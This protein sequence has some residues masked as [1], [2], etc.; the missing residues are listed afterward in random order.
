M[1]D[2]TLFILALLSVLLISTVEGELGYQ[3]P[4]EI[5]AAHNQYR[6][7]VNVTPLT[8]SDTLAAQA[9]KCADSNAANLSSGGSFRHCFTPGYG[10]NIAQSPSTKGLNLT[11]MVDL[12]GSEKRYFVNGKFPSVS[13]TGSPKDVGHYTQ[14]IWQETKQVGCGKASASGRDILVCDYSPEGNVADTVVYSPLPPQP[15]QVG[16]TNLYKTYRTD[17]VGAERLIIINTVPNRPVSC[18]SVSPV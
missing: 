9:Q 2:R 7:E 15:V 4:Q 8:W 16:E 12:W 17:F 1:C 5:L 14:I 13:S 18:Y 3:D 6:A 10:Q 11:Q